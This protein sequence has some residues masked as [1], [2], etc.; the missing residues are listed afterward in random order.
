L[1]PP[2]FFKKYRNVALAMIPMQIY[3]RTRPA[4]RSFVSEYDMGSGEIY[5][6]L[7]RFRFGDGEKEVA[8]RGDTRVGL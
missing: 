5:R 7:A 2:T 6:G 8:Y 4:V 3:A 1:A